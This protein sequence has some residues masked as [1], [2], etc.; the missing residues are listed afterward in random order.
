MNKLI[1][2]TSV[3]L[4]GLMS[5]AV[6][7]NQAAQLDVEN[8]F[9]REMPPVAPA[10]GAFMT[11]INSSDQPIA[12]VRADSDAAKTVELHTHIHDNG[13]MRMREI[14]EI[15]VPAMGQTELKPG[16]LHVML[17]GPTR[18]LKAG[19]LVDIK[20]IMQ[21]GSEKMIQAPVRKIM[22]MGQMQGGG[23]GMGH[24]RH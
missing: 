11:L 9:V 14:P 16:G 6:Q 17:I 1:S 23:H 13:V 5:L 24:H 15:S 19:D 12:V 18:A 10:T 2:L 4:A 22:G 7:A 20:L 3:A 21:D 8:P